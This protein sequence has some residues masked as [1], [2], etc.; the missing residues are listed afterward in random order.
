MNFDFSEDQKLLQKTAR[1]FLETF[2][3]WSTFCEKYEE[4]H[5]ELAADIVRRV[6]EENRK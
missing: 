6:A 1:D 3:R 4:E 5:V 2:V